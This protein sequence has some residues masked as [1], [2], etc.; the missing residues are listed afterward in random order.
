[1]NSIPLT[2]L[3]KNTTAQHLSQ[4]SPLQSRRC[5]HNVVM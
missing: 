5:N 3:A 2:S 4:T 1:M